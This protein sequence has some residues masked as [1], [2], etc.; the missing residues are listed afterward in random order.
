MSLDKS[1]KSGKEKR[2]E[3]RGAKKIDHTCRNHGSCSYCRD[4]RLYSKKIKHIDAI[5]Q[6]E[7][8]Q[9]PPSCQ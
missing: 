9:E 7:E 8:H 2:R 3:Y 5:E 1:I 4:N 6:I